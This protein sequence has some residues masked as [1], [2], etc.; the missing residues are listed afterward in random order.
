LL[1]IFEQGKKEPI[2]GI[3]DSMI[4]SGKGIESLGTVL[5]GIGGSGHQIG[6][7]MVSCRRFSSRGFLIIGKVLLNILLT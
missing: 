3:L 7:L 1:L 6:N 4:G 5:K 2:N